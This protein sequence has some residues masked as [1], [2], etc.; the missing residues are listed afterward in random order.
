[1]TH[2][3]YIITKWHLNLECVSLHESRKEI[4]ETNPFLLLYV[5]VWLRSKM[6]V[7]S[8]MISWILF[9]TPISQYY[10]T[11]ILDGKRVGSKKKKKNYFSSISYFF[12]K[13]KKKSLE[14]MIL[15]ILSLFLEVI[16]FFFLVPLLPSI[17]T[18][19]KIDRM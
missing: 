10:F 7:I 4:V 9:D 18:H 17:Q 6:E 12:K 8:T 1:M 5:L 15:S 14:Y 11:S 3:R 16:I 2:I 19:S 13:V